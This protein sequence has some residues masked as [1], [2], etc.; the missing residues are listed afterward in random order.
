MRIRRAGDAFSLNTGINGPGKGGVF[1]KTARFTGIIFKPFAF[2]GAL[3]TAFI[4]P[5]DKTVRRFFNDRLLI[6][7][8]VK[9]EL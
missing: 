6:D 2:A 7:G 8:G 5:E 4:H 1:D 3:N 9:T